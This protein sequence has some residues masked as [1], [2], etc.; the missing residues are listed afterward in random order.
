M[1]MAVMCMQVKKACVATA[2]LT[3]VQVSNTSSWFAKPSKS[4]KLKAGQGFT[5][6][7]AACAAAANTKKGCAAFSLNVK[8]GRNADTTFCDLHAPFVPVRLCTTGDERKFSCA[9]T[10]IGSWRAKYVYTS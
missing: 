10:P 1:L 7:Q 2:D 3:F 4:T 5:E 8:P 9:R 6:C